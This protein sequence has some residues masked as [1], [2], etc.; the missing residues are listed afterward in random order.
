MKKPGENWTS[1]DTCTIFSCDKDG[2]QFSVSSHQESCPNIDDC[3]EE[4]IYSK[5]CC[6]HCNITSASLCK[7]IGEMKKK[8]NQ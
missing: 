3:P 5:G 1:E 4:N 8:L 6:K 7:S 2:D